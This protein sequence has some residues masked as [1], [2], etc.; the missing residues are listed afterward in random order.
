MFD[1]KAI[2]EQAKAMIKRSYLALIVVVFLAGVLGATV[3]GG[4]IQ[5]VD[6]SGVFDTDSDVDFDDS[7]IQPEADPDVWAPETQ[8]GNPWEDVP[9]QENPFDLTEMWRE[10]ADSM[11]IALPILIG[12]IV[13]VVLIAMV[14]ALLFGIFVSNVVTSGLCG[15]LMRYWRGENPSIGEL[16]A[17]F[18]NY[19]PVL[20]AMFLRDLYTFL[21]SLLFIIPGIVKGL[22]YSMVPYIIYENPNLT[23]SQALKISQK[24]TDGAK[25]DLFVLGLSFIGWNIL[26]ALT[27]GLLGIFYVNP[28]MG[29]TYAGVYDQLKWN[30]IQDGRLT[31]TDFGQVVPAPE[32]TAPAAPVE[33]YG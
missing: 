13:A 5:T 6:I 1:R 21:W 3:G 24:M 18:R 14:T 22:A 25:G 23:A 12:V 27:G 33:F 7:D 10:F 20:G 19:R 29:L 9:Q 28:Y 8:T 4:T 15:W 2:K 30:A 31:W 32:W 26:T 16:F 11:G 17:S